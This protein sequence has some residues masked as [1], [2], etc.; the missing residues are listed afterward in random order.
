[1]L[2]T[3]ALLGY[4]LVSVGFFGFCV[5]YLMALRKLYKHTTGKPM[6]DKDLNEILETIL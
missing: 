3:T 4:Y 6:T 5:G 2:V 1:M